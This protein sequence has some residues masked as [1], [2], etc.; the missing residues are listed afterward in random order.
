MDTL[1]EQKN[2]SK[3]KTTRELQKTILEVDTIE[4]MRL[5]VGRRGAGALC[6]DINERFCNIKE[7]C[8]HPILITNNPNV[9]P[10]LISSENIPYHEFITKD[11]IFFCPVCRHYG[12]MDVIDAPN[13]EIIEHYCVYLAYYCLTTKEYTEKYPYA[14]YSYESHLE[15]HYPQASIMRYAALRYQNLIYKKA[16]DLILTANPN[17]DLENLQIYLQTNLQQYMET[18]I[19]DDA[20]NP[21]LCRLTVPSE[22]I[23]KYIIIGNPSQ[24][25]E[26]INHAIEENG[27]PLIRQ[28]IKNK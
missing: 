18:A 28:K 11:N 16:K 24:R 20:T 23:E 9:V 7:N 14:P 25:I 10:D 6:D 13:N 27:F 22:Y 17:L 15:H 1:N 21:I 4:P 3:R 26:E 8:I 12:Y 2:L 5:Y 19:K